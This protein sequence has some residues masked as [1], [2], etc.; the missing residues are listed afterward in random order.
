[1][2]LSGA[3]RGTFEQVASLRNDYSEDCKRINEV[4]AYLAT[5]DYRSEQSF[6]SL[7]VAQETRARNPLSPRTDT[8][9]KECNADRQIAVPS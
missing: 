3:L 2:T 4:V 9:A 6:C 1:M 7:R 8:Q 5:S